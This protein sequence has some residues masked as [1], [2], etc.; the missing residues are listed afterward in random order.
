MSAGEERCHDVMEHLE[1]MVFEDGY[2]LEHVLVDRDAQYEAPS[3]LVGQGRIPD[4]QSRHDLPRD[5]GASGPAP[6]RVFSWGRSTIFFAWKY[7][8]RPSISL[9][10]HYRITSLPSLAHIPRFSILLSIFFV[11]PLS[12]AI[13]LSGLQALLPSHL[14]MSSVSLSERRSTIDWL[15]TKPSDTPFAFSDAL[16]LTP[17]SKIVP[18]P[19]V[20]SMR[21][22]TRIESAVGPVHFSFNLR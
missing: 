6:A 12:H 15:T 2:T 20:D 9:V 4:L 14:K 7:G 16:T 10:Q 22:Y 5:C 3:R 19:D 21:V 1:V 17:I 11:A 13:S 18:S 8:R